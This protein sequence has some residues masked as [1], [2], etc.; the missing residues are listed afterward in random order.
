[1]LKEK[2]YM[3]QINLKG[4]YFCV[5]LH[6]KQRKFICL[7]LLTGIAAD[8][9]LYLYFCIKGMS[10]ATITHSLEAEQLDSQAVDTFQQ[11]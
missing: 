5:T 3:C 11:N 7:L 9:Y 6:P 8:K 1:M 10:S 4:A 2:G